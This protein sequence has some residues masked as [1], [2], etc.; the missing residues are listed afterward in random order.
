MCRV[1]L[2]LLPQT[3][4][5]SSFFHLRNPANNQKSGYWRISC[6]CDP[7]NT[8]MELSADYYHLLLECC[9]HV[10]GFILHG[11]GQ[12]A[13]SLLNFHWFPPDCLCECGRQPPSIRKDVKYRA[14]RTRI[15]SGGEGGGERRG[16]TP[17]ARRRQIR[18]QIK[19]VKQTM[20]Q[21]Q[22]QGWKMAFGQINCVWNQ[23]STYFMPHL[24]E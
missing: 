21:R 10:L 2:Q 18:R 15:E 12:V 6:S 4:N 20:I 13:C 22:R 1:S 8:L 3:L 23:I 11:T 14:R 5:A 9:V 7:C 17:M 19:E 16:A 24:A